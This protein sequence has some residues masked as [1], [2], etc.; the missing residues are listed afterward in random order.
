M[1]L[2]RCTAQRGRLQAR[3]TAVIRSL[4]AHL[5]LA[6]ILTSGAADAQNRRRLGAHDVDSLKSGVIV[7][8]VGVDTV[9][10]RDDGSGTASEGV[11]DRHGGEIWAGID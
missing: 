8:F 9:I 2:C 6:D 10:G 7:L 5:I 11:S 1:T 4:T 3:A